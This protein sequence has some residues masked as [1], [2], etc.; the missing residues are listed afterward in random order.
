M[1]GI[2]E[3]ERIIFARLSEGLVPDYLKMVNDLENVGRLIGRTEP[4]TEEKEL[5]WVR[6]KLEAGAPVFS[7]LEKE[8]GEFIGNIEFMDVHD[9]VGELGIAITAGKQDMGYGSEAIPAMVD[10]G[11]NA[12]GL[13]RV[14]LKV[15]PDNAR[16]IK[17]YLKCGFREYDR[18]DDH[19][20]MELTQ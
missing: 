13:E 12:L 9:R 11:M 2:F 20:Y 18:D 14:F 19:V 6:K 8:S 7:M 5:K 16:A 15:F 1:N 3:T 4:V 10:H 17:V